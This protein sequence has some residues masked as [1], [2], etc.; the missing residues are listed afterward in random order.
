M[1][2]PPS[3]NGTL[4]SFRRTGQGTGVST[5][6]CD[7]TSRTHGHLPTHSHLEPDV[8]VGHWV[9]MVSGVHG[10][11]GHCLPGEE[12]GK[13]R[14]HGILYCSVERDEGT[15]RERGEEDFE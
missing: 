7:P 11:H 2:R 6:C 4:H 9:H 13:W 12:R 1:P 8:G 3:G 10:A 5:V 14:M 15:G